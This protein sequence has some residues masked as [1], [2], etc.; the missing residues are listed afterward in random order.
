[1]DEPT[2]GLHLA[3]LDRLLGIV[4]RLIAGGNTGGNAVVVIE[5]NLENSALLQRICPVSAPRA[6]SSL[7][8]FHG[9]R[10]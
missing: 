3:D 10:R 1:M 8:H 6:L 4:E 9:M 5:H 7:V 2:I